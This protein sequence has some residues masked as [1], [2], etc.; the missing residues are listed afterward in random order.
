MPFNL[1]LSKW[2][3][4]LE[5][6]ISAWPKAS[7]TKTKSLLFIY[8]SDAKVCLKKCGP[9]FDLFILDAKEFIELEKQQIINAVDGFPLQAR[10]LNGENY[11]EEVYGN[12]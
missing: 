12:K 5:V 4:I 1:S 3:Y 6:F 10:D 8:K 7:W 11:Y 2:V 9:F